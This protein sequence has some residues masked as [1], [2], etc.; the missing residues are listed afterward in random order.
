M[1]WSPNRIDL[2]IVTQLLC[3]PVHIYLFVLFVSSFIPDGK[4]GSPYLG[5]TTAAARAALSFLQRV[6]HFQT[7]VW[8]PMLGVL[9][10]HTDVDARDCSQGCADTVRESALK[11]GSGRK[12]PCRTGDS[13]LRQRRAGPIWFDL[14]IFH[15]QK[16]KNKTKMTTTKNPNVTP[17]NVRTVLM[18]VSELTYTKTLKTYKT[19]STVGV[20]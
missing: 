19:R 14:N 10:V 6:Q 8:L 9:N 3:V 15:Y 7:K 20:G 17:N 18:S 13:N 11:L 2:L 4:F 12:I 5:K 1:R 16:N